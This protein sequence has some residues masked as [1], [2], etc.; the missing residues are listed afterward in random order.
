MGNHRVGGRSFQSP[1]NE[2]PSMLRMGLNGT[3]HP[4][5]GAVEEPEVAVREPS[6]NERPRVNSREN[7]GVYRLLWVN[8]NGMSQ[9]EANRPVLG[10]VA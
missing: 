1:V 4:R 7:T 6:W 5:M 2:K 10:C 9:L 8:V 3:R